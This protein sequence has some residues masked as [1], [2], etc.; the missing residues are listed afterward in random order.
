MNSGIT[1]EIV[2]KINNDELNYLKLT[3]GTV[4]GQVTIDKS[5]DEFQED[6]ESIAYKV[7]F[8]TGSNQIGAVSFGK[9]S[10]NNGAMV[11][12]EQV[13]GTTRLQFRAS[14]TPGA[15]VWRQPEASSQLY[16]DVDSINFRLKGNGEVKGFRL[17]QDYFRPNSNN[18]GSLGDSSHNFLALYATTVYE[19]GSS[20]SEKY[21]LKT[22]TPNDVKISNSKII[23]SK[24]DTDIGTGINI[25]DLKIALDFESEIGAYL[26]LTGGTLTGNLTAP[27]ITLTGESDAQYTAKLFGGQLTH[28]VVFHMPTSGG[29]LVTQETVDST[30]AEKQANLVAGTNIKNINNESVL[31]SGSIFTGFLIDLGTGTTENPEHIFTAEQNTNFVEA[32]TVLSDKPKH[33]VIECSYSYNTVNFFTANI[34][35]TDTGAKC[36]FMVNGGANILCVEVVSTGTNQYKSVATMLTNGITSTQVTMNLQ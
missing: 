19:N 28:N 8:K 12:F 3:G 7:R 36:Y 24:D 9:E 10:A 26:P 27:T 1:S 14:N 5:S 32:F 17:N 16:L 35:R 25:A 31:G 11:K 34:E 15:M 22:E 2:S 4:N 18:V 21:A 29:T 23:L 6:V 33:C 13:E 20:L 30:L